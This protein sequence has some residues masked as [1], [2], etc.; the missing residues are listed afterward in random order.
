MS[1]QVHCKLRAYQWFSLQ[2]S[3]PEY[4]SLLICINGLCR[5]SQWKGSDHCV[6]IHV[7]CWQM[8]PCVSRPTCFIWTLD[9]S[10]VMNRC[11]A[12][13]AIP[14]TEWAASD[15]RL[16]LDSSSHPPLC[17]LCLSGDSCQ[18]LHLCSPC[19]SAEQL[20]WPVRTD[21]SPPNL[22]LPRLPTT[23][24]A[25]MIV[26]LLTPVG[27]TVKPLVSLLWLSRCLNYHSIFETGLNTSL[28]Q[29][30]S[31]AN[32][33]AGLISQERKSLRGLKKL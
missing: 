26:P 20:E 16:H 17:P 13:W 32:G 2:N 6:F 8:F 30:V 10:P 4:H 11:A 5:C 28:S 15:K 1:L 12:G 23:V 14:V 29:R 7:S 3:T 9:V 21:P 27:A 18:L 24:T 25:L 31:E 19:K 33:A 22:L